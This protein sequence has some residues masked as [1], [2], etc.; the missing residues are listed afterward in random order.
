MPI[1]LDNV[2]NDIA[3]SQVGKRVLPKVFFHPALTGTGGK[4]GLLTSFRNP[5]YTSPKATVNDANINIRRKK[6]VNGTTIIEYIPLNPLTARA[7][8]TIDAIPIPDLNKCALIASKN[9]GGSNVEVYFEAK[10]HSLIYEETPK[11]DGGNTKSLATCYQIFIYHVLNK[12]GKTLN[13]THAV[14]PS[15]VSNNFYFDYT[16]TPFQLAQKLVTDFANKGYTA[17]AKAVLDYFDNYSLFEAV[18]DRVDEWN[19]TLDETLDNYFKNVSRQNSRRPTYEVQD[20]IRSLENYNVPLDLY[21]KI[22]ASIDKHFSRKKD[23]T[24]LCKQNLSLLL[25]DRLH[26]LN[27]KMAKLTSI[28]ALPANASTAHLAKFSTE[29]KKAITSTDPLVL[30]QAGA[31]TGKSTVILGRI[32]H[33]VA[34]GIDPHDITVLSFTNAAADHIRELNPDV[35]SMT[36]AS[37]IHAIYELNFPDH[38]LSNIDTMLNCINIYFKNDTTAGEFRRRLLAI[39]KNER[40]AFTAM[41]NFV[42]EHYDDTMNMLDT[43]KQTSLELEII[44]CY[45]MIDTLKEPPEVSSKYLIIDEV[46]DNSIFEFVYT[47]KYIDKH[48][49]SLFIVG[50]CSQTLYEFRSSNPKALNV[51]EGSGV[52]S[53]Y[54]LQVNYR[55]NQEILDFANVVLADIE[56]NRYANIQLKANSL[57]PV[58]T[59]SF[60]EKVKLFYQKLPK[61]S[62]FTDAIGPIIA[63][64]VKSYIDDKLAK[65]EKVCLLAYTRRNVNSAKACLEH[66]YPNKNVVSIVPEKMSEFDTF[67]KF[68]ERYWDEVTVAPAR[69]IVTIISRQIVKHLDTLTWNAQKS[70]KAVRLLI[71]KWYDQNKEQFNMWTTMYGSKQMTKKELLENIR[72]TLIDFEREYNALKFTRL[73]AKNNETKQDEA[74]KKA[75]IVLSTIHSAKGLEFDNCIVLYQDDTNLTEEKK[76][77]YYVALTRAMKSEFIIAYGTNKK[78][79]I[80]SDHETIVKTLSAKAKP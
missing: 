45:Q 32:N 60:S 79:K 15:L 61:L 54:Q 44:I 56:A 8:D 19:E 9:A 52:F 68:I 22:Y 21:K 41:N 6:V 25:S 48:K 73:T 53:T 30:V 75:D 23:K 36:I 24:D 55:S 80:Q 64:E 11:K 34:C 29:Q 76:R 12:K 38:K 69:S 42:E 7:W 71:T 62:D 67:T 3:V 26:R 10:V 4:I 57:A 20:V 58:T 39:K 1:S 31:G 50:D 77:M 5:I 66:M 40:D 33:M 78:A 63:K 28:P 74:V 13:A 72:D 65:K 70:D 59:Q 16:A 27:N 43:I 46:Q 2:A 35:G 14:F 49:E 37:M 51:L 47:L 18:C 17:D